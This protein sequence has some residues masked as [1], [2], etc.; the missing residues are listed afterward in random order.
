MKILLTLYIIVKNSSTEFHE[1]PSKG[2]A[3]DT[4][5]NG[6]V[7]V[8]SIQR[9]HLFLLKQRHK[10]ERHQKQQGKGRWISKTCLAYYETVADFQ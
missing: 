5:M 6:E 10:N 2:L 1:G 9:I 7:D 4:V 3:P 8:V